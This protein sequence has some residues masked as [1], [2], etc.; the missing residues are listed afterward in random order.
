MLRRTI[1][2]K[3]SDHPFCCERRHSKSLYCNMCSIR[4]EHAEHSKNKSDRLP[5]LSEECKY[6]QGGATFC[7]QLLNRLEAWQHGSFNIG[8]SN[9][10]TK[11]KYS[12]PHFHEAPG[13]QRLASNLWVGTQRSLH[14]DWYLSIHLSVDCYPQYSWVVVSRRVVVHGY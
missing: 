4:H 13:E 10:Y 8:R 2:E 5:G 12:S 14:N 11:G 6:S 1:H 3:T 7:T 9:Y